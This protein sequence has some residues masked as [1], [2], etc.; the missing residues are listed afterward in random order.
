M[1]LGVPVPG[2]ECVEEL[3]N[4]G[5]WR[6]QPLPCVGFVLRVAARACALS[7]EKPSQRK[8]C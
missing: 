8:R 5:V 7:G 4:A 6:F 2:M 1:V 3:E